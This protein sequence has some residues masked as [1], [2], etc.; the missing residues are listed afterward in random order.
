MHPGQ[1]RGIECDSPHAWWRRAGDAF[2]RSPREERGLP[3]S[4]T[5][6]LV[7]FHDPADDRVDVHDRPAQLQ[8]LVLQHFA[9]V[10]RHERDLII[11]VP[12]RFD[13]AFQV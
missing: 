4:Q 3:K 7:F 6:P 10:A 13:A 9:A 11:H 1:L 12:D 8:G 2:R 5:R